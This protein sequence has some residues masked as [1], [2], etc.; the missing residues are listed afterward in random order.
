MREEFIENLMEDVLGVK[1]LDARANE[2]TSGNV[3]PSVENGRIR[4]EESVSGRDLSTLG[5]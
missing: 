2:R 5:V 4:L 3:S 1:N